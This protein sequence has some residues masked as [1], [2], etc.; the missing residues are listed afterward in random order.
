MW[1]QRRERALGLKIDNAQR[2]L[3]ARG[4]RRF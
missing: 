1:F 3:T 2:R 4:T